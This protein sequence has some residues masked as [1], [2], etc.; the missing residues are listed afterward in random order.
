MKLAAHAGIDE[1]N[2]DLLPD[3]LDIA[4]APILKW[5]GRSLAAAFIHGTLV[6]A[7]RRMRINLVRLAKH[8]VD[9][10]AI[11]LPSR[12]ARREVLVGIRNPLVVLFLVFVF[13]GVRRGIA[14]LPES[15]NEV[16][17]LFIV[18][19]L[20]ESCSLFIGDDV[21]HVFVEPLLVR[22][23][24]FLLECP[25]V[26]LLLLLIGT[27][28]ERIDGILG[29]RWCGCGCILGR[30]FGGLWIHGCLGSLRLRLV[31]SDGSGSH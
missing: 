2:N 25:L 26:P 8:D 19:E 30:S 21:N 29:R 16:V 12:D 5:E 15:F 28:L 27:A 10:A 7:A 23:A 20:L 18:R 11:G 14:P 4:V 31:L 3:T 17:A 1:F 24:Q 9:S 6:A 22:L 13:F